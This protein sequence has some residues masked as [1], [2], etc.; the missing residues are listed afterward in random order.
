[1]NFVGVLGAIMIVV[2][3]YL[4]VWGKCKDYKLSLTS[5]TK[6]QTTIKKKIVFMDHIF[7]GYIFVT[8]IP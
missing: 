3:L 8:S 7:V 6:E 2:D 4:V 5:S 1:M